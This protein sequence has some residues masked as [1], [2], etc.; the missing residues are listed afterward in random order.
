MTQAVA[1]EIFHMLFKLEV[2][3]NGLML[4]ILDTFK[5]IRMRWMCIG[6]I[7]NG[8]IEHN[9]S[10]ELTSLASVHSLPPL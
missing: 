4:D 5:V 2:V 3:W 7:E 10:L 8:S 1:R 6:G 9:N